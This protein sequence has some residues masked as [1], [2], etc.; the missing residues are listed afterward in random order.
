M[1]IETLPKLKYINYLNRY[2]GNLSLNDILWLSNYANE[3][4]G[5]ITKIE[6]LWITDP[7]CEIIVHNIKVAEIVKRHISLRIN[8]YEEYHKGKHLISLSG[9]SIDTRTSI[10]TKLHF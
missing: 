6:Y 7:S 4:I 3:E 9:H 1:D 10:S 8:V 5:K 2:I